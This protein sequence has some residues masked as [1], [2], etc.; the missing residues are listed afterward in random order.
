M[1][2][3][4]LFQ[5][6]RISVIFPFIDVEVCPIQIVF[7]IAIDISRNPSLMI[8]G[9]Y[10]GLGCFDPAKSFPVFF[11]G[12]TASTNRGWTRMNTDESAADR[13]SAFICVHPRFTTEKLFLICRHLRTYGQVL[14]TL[15]GSGNIPKK[16]ECQ[17]LFS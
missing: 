16:S 7:I 13:S 10:V 8:H 5:S 3:D 12:K 9:K 6:I 11:S 17:E 1:E 14:I 4:K 15:L 2:T